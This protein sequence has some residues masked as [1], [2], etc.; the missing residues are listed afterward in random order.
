MQLYGHNNQDSTT[1]TTWSLPELGI[2]PYYWQIVAE[3]QNQTAG[4]VWQFS[5][6]PTLLVANATLF[7]ALS[8]GTN[9]VF[10][11]T[12]S[13]PSMQTVTVDFATAD[14]TAFAPADYS[15]TNGTLFFSPGVT[16]QAISV[17][18]T[19]SANPPASRTF[20]VN[21]SNPQN[22]PLVATQ[23]VGTLVNQL[24][25][26]PALL[27]IPNQTNHAGTVVAVTAVVSNSSSPG[28]TFTF[29][30][31]PGAPAGALINPGTGQFAWP[32]TDANLGT[33][34]ITVR[35]VDNNATNF[36]ATQTF[37]AIVRARPT[38]NSISNF[39]GQIMLGWTAIPGKNY[40]VQS[41]ATLAGPWT[42]VPGDVV[43][44][45]AIA[46]IV[47]AG[48]NVLGMMPHPENHVEPEMGCTDGRGLFAGLVEA[49]DRAA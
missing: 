31:D 6:V 13:A 41:S 24:G 17:G 11:V 46:G 42:G 20:L 36:T 1:N 30:L 19:S 27:P 2:G 10:N 21:F 4:P 44:T 14:N 5:S 7:E 48:G 28:D 25:S 35:A 29:S 45:N 40:R 33:N 39:G 18:I 26:L 8:G 23:A 49:L 15:P 16:N 37:A 32:T 34:M 9:L 38:I 12:L 22:A 3:R 43:A 47:S